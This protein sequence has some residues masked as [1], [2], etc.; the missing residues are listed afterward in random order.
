MSDFKKTET[1]A[2]PR[3]SEEP[4]TNDGLSLASRTLVVR[5]LPAISVET[6][7]VLNRMGFPELFGDES[8]LSAHRKQHSSSCEPGG[9]SSDEDSSGSR[10][11][12]S[13]P[14]PPPNHPETQGHLVN[15]AGGLFPSLSPSR[16][17]SLTVTS[18]CASD[19]PADAPST[20][21]P[22]RGM[23]P[24]SLSFGEH[25][26][27]TPT[28][29]S[30]T[31]S[32]RCL[33]RPVGPNDTVESPS[34]NAAGFFM[35]EEPV[36]PSPTPNRKRATYSA[37][38]TP[39]WLPKRVR[40]GS[41]NGELESQLGDGDDDSENYSNWFSL[42]SARQLSNDLV[43]VQQLDNEND[44]EDDSQTGRTV[45]TPQ[46]VW[47]NH[48]ESVLVPLSHQGPLDPFSDGSRSQSIL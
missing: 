42:S 11:L 7:G 5:C 18:A 1:D 30:K 43:Q 12:A 4:E 16:E 47:G 35:R 6:E 37:P 9:R 3:Q 44:D 40:I 45:C 22:R 27:I 17:S 20:P 25:A 15:G 36:T 48:D 28:S 26:F 13:T 19:A 39:P 21:S 34:K 46:L 31:T 41:E 32:S 8:S 38:S 2:R 24:Y 14:V 29:I 23:N 10:S 33:D